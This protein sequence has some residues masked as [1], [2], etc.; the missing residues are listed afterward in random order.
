MESKKKS[1]ETME[2]ELEFQSYY[3]EISKYGSECKFNWSMSPV[4]LTKFLIYLANNDYDLLL[5]L[6]N[7]IDEVLAL[8]PF[9]IPNRVQELIVEFQKSSNKYIRQ[10]RFY[11]YRAYRSYSIC[12]KLFEEACVQGN[13]ETVVFLIK[14]GVLPSNKGLELAKNNGYSN[15]IKLL[16]N[17][18]KFNST[19]CVFR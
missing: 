13:I 1:N 15:I 5:R 14:W 17:E 18:L 16:E 19:S 11:R 4:K 10:L 2:L 8:D 7:Q 12:E 6:D 3:E 9:W